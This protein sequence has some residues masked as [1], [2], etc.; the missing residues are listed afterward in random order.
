MNDKVSASPSEFM[1]LMRQAQDQAA[2]ENLPMVEPLQQSLELD[3]AQF[4][5]ALGQRVGLPVVTMAAINNM[6]AAI[7]NH[8]HIINRPL[9]LQQPH[10][11]LMAEQ[12]WGRES[13]LSEKSSNTLEDI[14]SLFIVKARLLTYA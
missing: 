5:H 3:N 13:I 11:M 12:A 6:A 4:L 10:V 8:N 1:G 14:Q 7:S 2:V 9:E